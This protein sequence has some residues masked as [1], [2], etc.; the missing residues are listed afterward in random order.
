MKCPIWMLIGVLALTAPSMTHGAEGYEIV[1]E[2]EQPPGNITVTPDGRIVFSMMQFFETELRAGELVDGEIVPFPNAQWSL[3]GGKDHIACDS[4]LGIASDPLGIVWMLDNGARGASTPKLIGWDTRTDTLHKVIYIAEPVLAEE[5]FLND[6]AVDRTHNKV[7][8]SDTAGEQ[9]A[10]VIVDLKTGYSR[11]VLEGHTST[12]PKDIDLVIDGRP[13][14]SRTPEGELERPRVAVNGIALDAQNEWLYFCP[15]SG[16]TMYRAP[17]EAL[18]DESL[19][20]NQL[21]ATVETYF[22]GKPISDGMGIDHAGNIYLTCVGKN[23]VGV[24]TPEREFKML[25]QDDDIV[26]WPDGM[27]YAPD[28]YMYIVANQLHLLPR[29]TGGAM[30]AEPPYYIIRFQALAPGVIGR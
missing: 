22:S 15:F 16:E 20:A 19:S 5:S 1:A 8:I 24:I 10:I 2:L 14:Q 27:S 3:G 29:M 26:R 13:A 7:F 9:G 12:V 6:M 17:V 18:L 25:F 11:R 21:A 4:I 23:G 28:G 30:E